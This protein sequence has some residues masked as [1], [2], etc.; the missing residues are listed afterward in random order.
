M[1][2]N[3]A[4]M[5][6]TLV[7]VGVCSIGYAFMHEELLIKPKLR[8][9]MAQKFKDPSSLQFQRENLTAS[10]WICGEVNAKNSYGAYDGFV[11]YVT[12]GTRIFIDKP[13]FANTDSTD[14]LTTLLNHENTILRDI[15]S[16]RKARPNA[17]IAA[18]TE[19]SLQAAAWKVVFEEHWSNVCTK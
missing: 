1:G 8:E 3:R 2:L 5:F 11:R 13:E 12:N 9:Q 19:A 17:M 15:L 4:W 14:D 7:V 18:P 10:G 16:D 6:A